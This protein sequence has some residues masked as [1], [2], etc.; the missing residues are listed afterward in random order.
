MIQMP[1][2][3]HPLVYIKWTDAIGKPESWETLDDALEWGDKDYWHVETV[4]WILKETKEY[5]LMASKRGLQ[6]GED[7][8]YGQLF[9][10]PKPWILERRE[11]TK[12]DK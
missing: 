10:L 5:I 6:V 7:T 4:G 3:S 8:H 12:K 11:L 9:K 1:A 2:Q